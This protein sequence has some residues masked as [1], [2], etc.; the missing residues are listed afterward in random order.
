MTEK[1][2]LG[3]AEPARKDPRHVPALRCEHQ[4]VHAPCVPAIPATALFRR[5]R[6]APMVDESV[7][8]KA[9]PLQAMCLA[10]GAL[11]HE[12]GQQLSQEASL[13]GASNRAKAPRPSS[14][15]IACLGGELRLE[16]DSESA[17]RQGINTQGLDE[18]H[19]P[20]SPHS[21]M[22]LV[23]SDHLV[24]T[25]NSGPRQRLIRWSRTALLI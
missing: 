9:R 19:I 23:P 6:L 4:Y 24:R 7:A 22:I 13:P 20:G 18:V 1:N 10:P 2:A 25:C 3:C 14:T 21:M 16:N 8:A 15:S 17:Q 5:K 11:G 12:V